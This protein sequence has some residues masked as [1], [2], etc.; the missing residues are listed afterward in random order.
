MVDRAAY[1]VKDG[2][3]E[4]ASAPPGNHVNVVLMYHTHSCVIKCELQLMNRR[5]PSL[6]EMKNVATNIGRVCEY[7]HRLIADRSRLWLQ[8]KK[9][10]VRLNAH[11][12][13]AGISST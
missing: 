6:S 12:V 1:G 2:C 3:T 7:R 8:V 5:F 11:D 10:T 13:C 4:I 9:N